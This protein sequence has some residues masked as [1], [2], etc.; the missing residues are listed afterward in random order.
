[1]LPPARPRRP[2]NAGSVTFATDLE[3][4]G[5]APALVVAGTGEVVSYA[6]LAERADA[7]AARL[8]G[9]NRGHRQL[10]LLE[11]TNTVDAVAAELGCL[12]AGHPVLLVPPGPH[13]E[14]LTAAYDPDAVVRGGEVQLRR[15]DPQAAPHDLHPDLA[16]LLSTS[17]STGA[18]KLVRL[19]ATNLTSN[20][21]AI[22]RLVM[23]RSPA[24]RPR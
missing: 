3:R 12:R 5:L 22:G 17:G 20:A 4:H 15:T 2:S 24:S 7:V 14:E 1:M 13:A 6:E 16:L 21:E 9:P 8:A 11:A 10:V 18:P 23:A 19:S